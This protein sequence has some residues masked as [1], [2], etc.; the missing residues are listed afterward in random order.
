MK[1][2][3]ENLEKRIT[4]FAENTIR[5]CRKLK[6]DSINKRLIEQCVAASGSIGANYFEATEA[7]SK[8]DFVHKMKIAKKEIKEVK[9]WLQLLGVANEQYVDDFRILWKEAHELLLIFSKIVHNAEKEV[10]N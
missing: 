9:H 7:E 2:Y 8:K 10:F 3:F 6:Q 4:L 5:L 1:S